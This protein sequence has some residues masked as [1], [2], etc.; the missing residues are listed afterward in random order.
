[1]IRS[2]GIIG[3]GFVGGAVSAF[4]AI[5]QVNIYD[6]NRRE[7]N[8]P[9]DRKAAYSS[10]VVFINVPTDLINGRLDTSIVMSCVQDY[11]D[12]RDRKDNTVVIKSTIPVGLC[13]IIKNK[14]DLNNIVFNPEFLTQRTAL[15]DFISQKEVYLSGAPEHTSHIKRLYKE[16]FNY[17]QNFDVI[18]FET[19][20]H[21]QVE[22]LKLARNSYYALKVSFCNNI[23]NLCQKNDIDYESFRN[24][25]SNGE[26]VINQHTYVPGPDGKLGFGGKCLPK[27]VTELLNF[28][29]QSGVEFKMLEETIKFNEKQ[30]TR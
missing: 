9:E 1:M 28:A 15:A 19:K 7:Y 2:V 30:R 21:E 12:C 25:F 10:D 20:N 23:Y 27:D 6:I 8:S 29:S 26:W 5:K 11:I 14:F 17:H 4:S 16:F 24:C 13:N 18:F 3:F 22:L